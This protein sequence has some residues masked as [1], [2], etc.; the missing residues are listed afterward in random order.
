MVNETGAVA[1]IH[2]KAIL[3]IG[4]SMKQSFVWK[5]LPMKIYKNEI[6][7]TWDHFILV[8]VR[9]SFKKEF[10]QRV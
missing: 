8:L 7:S 9:V 2:N 6:K 10:W 1:D 4:Q 3:N 5:Y